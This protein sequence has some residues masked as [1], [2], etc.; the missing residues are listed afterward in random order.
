MMNKWVWRLP[1][2]CHDLILWATGFRLVK[3]QATPD[4]GW[5]W[6]T[7]TAIDAEYYWTDVYPAGE[8]DHE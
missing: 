8:E 6:S 5:M 4:P 3:E 1:S 2:W 7:N